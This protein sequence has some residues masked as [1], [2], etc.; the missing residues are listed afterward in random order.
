MAVA[1][2]GSMLV[3]LA[4]GGCGPLVDLG[5]ANDGTDATTSS[6]NDVAP[7][8]DAPAATTGPA[9]SASTSAPLSTTGPADTDTPADSGSNASSGGDTSGSTT[10][11]GEGESTTTGDVEP[12]PTVVRYQLVVDNIWTLENHPGALPDEAHFSWLGG[13]THDAG[14]SFWQVGELAS[15]GIVQM[16]EIGATQIL[17]TEVQ[18]AIDDG[19]ADQA[20]EWQQW[21][22]P[23]GTD[24]A[25]CGE[26]TVE[27][28][29][30]ID[31]P[32]LTLVSMLGPSPD[33][34]IG[35]S[36]LDMHEGGTWVERLV[37]DLRPYDGGTRSDMDFTMNGALQQPPEPISIITAESGQLVGPGSLG[38]MTFTR[39]DG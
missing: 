1:M 32:L 9:G 29:V 22:C 15:P 36:G 25:V 13:A 10:S 38:T 24:V 19:H 31:H 14:V 26:D 33:W 2:R 3:L 6:S 27:I 39:I 7:T 16:A 21:F 35:V 5:A 34:F 17:M 18:P 12:E 20:L 37:V 8:T 30:H 4:L 23:V 11:V 28:E